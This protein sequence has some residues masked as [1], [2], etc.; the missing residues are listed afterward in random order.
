[1]DKEMKYCGYHNHTMYSNFRIIDCVV[2]VEELIK[3]SDRKGYNALAIT[4]HETIASAIEALEIFNKLK[5]NG[6][7]K[8]LEKIILGNEIYLVDSLEEVRDNYQ[9]G[10]TKFPH[11]ILMAKNRKGFEAISRLSSK[12][13]ENSFFTGF[14]ERTPTTKEYL[15]E[16]VQ[17]EEYQNSLIATSACVGSNINIPLGKAMEAETTM[18]FELRDK[19]VED[20]KKEVLWCIDTFGKENFFLELQPAES[21][22]QLYC[23][24]WLIKFGNE[25][26]V[27]CILANDTHFIEKE[28]REVH[29]AFLQSKESE[30]EVDS[31]YQYCF[32]HSYSEM[33]DSMVKHIGE[34]EFKKATQTNSDIFYMIEDYS[35]SHSPIIPKATIPEFELKHVFSPAYDTYTSLK[36][37]SESE[38]E[39]DRYLLF[40]LEQGYFKELHYE[41]ISK[42]EFHK[43]LKRLDDEAS[44]IIGVGQAINQA[45]SGYYLTCREIVNIMWAQEDCGGGESMVGSGRGSGAGF[46]INY[47]LG[48]TQINP[49][50]Y[51]NMLHKRHLAKER[52]NG[53]AGSLPDIDIDIEGGR[54]QH[55]IEALKNHYGR[56]KVLQVS[57][58][59]TEGAKSSIKLACRSLGIDDAEAQYLASFI[60]TIRG[61]QFSIS[62]T[63][64]GDEENGIKPNKQFLNEMNKHK[65]LIELAMKVEGLVT[66]RGIHAGGVIIFNDPYW[67]TNAMMTASRGEVQVSQYNLHF[68]EIAGGTKFDVLSVENLDKIKSTINLLQQ[69]GLVDSSKTLR[70]NFTDLLHPKNLDLENKEYFDMASTGEISSLF[71]FSTEQGRSAVVKVNPNSFEELCAANSLMRLQSDDGEQPIDKYVRHKENIQLW[72]DEMRE[73]DLNEDEIKVLEKYLLHDYGINITQEVSMALSGDENIANFDVLE[74][75]KLRKVIA[76]PKGA[77]LDS[78]KELFYEKGKKQGTRKEMLDYVWN[79]Q[80]KMQFSYSFSSLHTCAYSII[81]VQ[82]LELN[83]RFPQI[84]WQTACLNVDSGAT[85]EDSEALVDYEKIAN[86][87]G[88][89]RSYGV[90]VKLPDINK[91]NY[92]FTPDAQNNAIIYGLKP[93]KTLNSKV[94]KD[95]MDNRPYNSLEDVFTKL[96][97]AK[98]ITNT[99]IIAMVKSGM[100]DSFGER[101]QIMM[102]VIRHI[103]D[104]KTTL[105]MQNVKLLLEANVLEGRPELELIEFRE[106]FKNNVLRKEATSNSKTKHKIFKVVDM[107]TYDKL[108]G[109]EGVINVMGNYYEVNEK[110]FKKVFDKKISKLKD[111]LKTEEPIKRANRYALNQQWLKYALGSYSK[112]EME[113]LSFYYHEHELAGVNSDLYEIANFSELPENVEI[114]SYNKYKGREIP[115]YKLHN[116]CGTVIAKNPTKHMVT[117]ITTDGSVVSVKYHSGSYSHYAKTVKQDGKVIEG[118]WFDKGNHLL[119]HGFRR[120]GQFVA[121][122]YKDSKTSTTTKLIEAVHEDGLLSYKLEREYI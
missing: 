114:E 39:D 1:M 113:T 99:H 30:R 17:M 107:E 54:R 117:L 14:L 70:E 20:A 43:I 72:Y 7:L 57:T 34:E 13:F 82:N 95:I 96:Y 15:R 36:Y 21:H 83:R 4:E 24:E 67:K 115:K 122:K 108:I 94:V 62:E 29:K 53:G 98:L 64:Y 76:K 65:G 116:V 40:L 38:Y 84:Y 87:I 37:L 79:V 32:L 68:S 77:A 100:L 51:H 19:F 102:E 35:L 91:S 58:Y 45:M 120:G 81:G 66:K 105:T 47:L 16:I 92:S 63:A 8:N 80:F 101:K 55:I 49:L 106:T 74:Q 46:L 22:I 28:D 6:E 119:V 88:K 59:G 112:W 23:N 93:V 60:D 2:R 121:K 12:A 42:D 3:A 111:W 56:D 78:V 41:G 11:F 75:N 61:K 50:L 71:Q 33:K 52:A 103:T 118:S 110:E 104:L 25:L 27:R 90:S 48:I 5:S 10:V 26:G 69:D 18:D 9:S 73:H 89:I 109:N 86:G 31:F 85:T 97:D 44:E